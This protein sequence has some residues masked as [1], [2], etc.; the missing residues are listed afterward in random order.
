MNTARFD[1]HDYYSG[2]ELK[3]IS[4]NSAATSPTNLYKKKAEF[5]LMEHILVQLRARFFPFVLS[6]YIMGQ[7]SIQQVATKNVKKLQSV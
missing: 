6:T 2:N 4:H 7:L 3:S 1:F 5:S